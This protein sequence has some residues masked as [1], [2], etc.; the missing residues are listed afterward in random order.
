MGTAARHITRS[1]NEGAHT[2]IP[3]PPRRNARRELIVR[4]M[5]ASEL[6][7]RSL[8]HAS[9]RSAAGRAGNATLLAQFP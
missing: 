6:R 3:P 9:S 1:S 8:L 5:M 7:S 2:L 4:A